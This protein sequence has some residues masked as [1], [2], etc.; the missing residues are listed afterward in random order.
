MILTKDP[1]PESVLVVVG[2]VERMRP[3]G[4]GRD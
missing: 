2:S 4:S 3:V 1:V